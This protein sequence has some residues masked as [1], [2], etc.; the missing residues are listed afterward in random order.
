[1]TTVRRRRRAR[2]RDGDVGD[3][4]DDARVLFARA[5]ETPRARTRRCRRE[6][7]ETVIRRRRH[8]DDGTTPAGTRGG[9]RRDAMRAGR[10]RGN[11]RERG[12]ENSRRAS[13]RETRRSDAPVRA[14]TANI[15]VGR[16]D[17]APRDVR[18]KKCARG[19]INGVKNTRVRCG[20]LVFPSRDEC[21]EQPPAAPATRRR[22]IMTRCAAGTASRFATTSAATSSSRPASRFRANGVVRAP[23]TR[24][25]GD[26]LALR[27]RER[28]RRDGV[29]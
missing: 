15:V 27:R 11:A 8:G 17:V 9:D 22:H 18:P 5:F 25:R 20:S 26:E 3:A 10:A 7:R 28:G 21:L 2:A 4:R 16:S 13:R 24:A 12:T 19:N 29:Q 1:M 14:E 6:R 23:R